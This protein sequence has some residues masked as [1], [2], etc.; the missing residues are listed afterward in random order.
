[1]WKASHLLLMWSA[2][3]ERKSYVKG[4]SK[5]KKTRV[6]QAQ[7]AYP[8]NSA[9]EECDLMAFPLHSVHF[10][11]HYTV[12]RNN[13]KHSYTTVWW[14]IFYFFHFSYKVWVKSTAVFLDVTN[15]EK[16]QFS[17]SWL[18]LRDSFSAGFLFSYGNRTEEIK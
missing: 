14:N 10:L 8:W 13:L 12:W 11:T 15:I 2:L 4:E 17:K 3:K 9:D 5:L 1:M 18:S 6:W 7:L 16:G